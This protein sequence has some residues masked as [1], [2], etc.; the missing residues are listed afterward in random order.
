MKDLYKILGVAENASEADIKKAYRALARENH[1]DATGGDAKR[2]ERFKEISDANAI[3]GDPKKRAEYD[4][5]R[6][7]PIGHDGMPQGFDPDSF[8][9][10]FGDFNIG[11]GRSPFAGG[12]GFSGGPGGPDLNDLFSNLFG[13]RGRTPWQQRGAAP[14]RGQDMSARVEL[15]F[16]EAALG[17][18]R[19]VRGGNGNPIEVAIPAG[20]ETGGRLRIARQGGAAPGAS[21]HPGD[22][23]LEITVTPHPYLLRE[24]DDVLLD[25]PITIAEAMVGARVHVPTLDGLVWV[26]VPPGSSTGRKLRLKGK[27][28]A[29]SDGGRGDQYCRVHVVVPAIEESDEESRRLLTELST[30]VVNTKLRSWENE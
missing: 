23:Y 6:H 10:V 24:G 17:T 9:S 21:G 19:K 30:R 2:T 16:A 8:A 22:L 1:P 11:K 4:R 20:V 3:I 14:A 26:N 12:G 18:K 15:P 13:Q 25:V 28:I 5:L 7:A 27:G 29:N